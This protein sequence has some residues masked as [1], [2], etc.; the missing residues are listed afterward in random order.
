MPLII[1]NFSHIL[2][3][4][5]PTKPS[6]FVTKAMV[7]GLKALMPLDLLF[8]GLIKFV[9]SE[10]RTQFLIIYNYFISITLP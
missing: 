1:L 9:R 10:D 2:G 6:V 7:N 3:M 4:A 8:Q 5:G